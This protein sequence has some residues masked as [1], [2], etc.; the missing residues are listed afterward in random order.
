MGDRRR[1][2]KLK[3]SGEGLDLRYQSRRQ[4][5]QGG[6]VRS[7]E[8]LIAE[9]HIPRL[10]LSHDVHALVHGSGTIG[11]F[12]TWLALKITKTVGSMWTAYIFAALT[13][14]SLP[15]AI[16]THQVIIIVA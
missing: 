3:N 16:A 7:P 6:N 5:P 2:W 11:R 9:R 10:V 1:S 12:N 13:L 8:H 14:I 15:A 4:P